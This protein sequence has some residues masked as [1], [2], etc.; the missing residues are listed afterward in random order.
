MHR[1]KS[2]A[3]SI[4][5][6][7]ATRQAGVRQVQVSSSE[8]SYYAQHKKKTSKGKAQLKKKETG[9]RDPAKP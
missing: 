2:P 1:K 8:H 5:K 7:K 4:R 3:S 9:K 6:G